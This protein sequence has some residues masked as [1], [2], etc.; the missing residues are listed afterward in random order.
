M[1][2][3]ARSIRNALDLNRL[4]LNI[5]KRIFK[6]QQLSAKYTLAFYNVRYFLMDDVETR[7]LSVYIVLPFLRRNYQYFTLNTFYECCQLFIMFK[8]AKQFHYV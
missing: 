2:V 7:V 1:Q 6:L 4:Q 5:F 3:F 8:Y